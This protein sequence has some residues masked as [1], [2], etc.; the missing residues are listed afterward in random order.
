MTAERRL[1]LRLTERDSDCT[2]VGRRPSQVVPRSGQD[3]PDEVSDGSEEEIQFTSVKFDVPFVAMALRLEPSPFGSK[4]TAKVSG[5]PSELTRLFGD[6]Y[7]VD[8]VALYN[9]VTSG[10]GAGRAATSAASP[11]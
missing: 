9:D 2:R 7:G 11:Q 1:E 4:D 8:C 10:F 3:R 5:S 6:T